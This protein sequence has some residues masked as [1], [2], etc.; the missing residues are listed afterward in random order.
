MSIVAQKYLVG[1]LGLA[2][3]AS[4][5]FAGF[6]DS[7]IR[8]RERPAV[9]APK[10]VVPLA[11]QPG[12]KIYQNYSCVLCH[13]EGGNHG[14]HNL[15]AQTGQQIPAL[16][17]VSESY[18]RPELIAKI[19]TGVPIEPKLDPNGP[20]PPLT[21]PGFGNSINDQQMADLIIYLYSLKPKGEEPG[22]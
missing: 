10:P 19:R 13:G 16:I 11:Q 12:L 8:K 3:L 21:M 18:T 7:R 4:V 17:H 6:Q 5:L 1:F 14:A 2:L 20:N 15:N 22:F 9:E